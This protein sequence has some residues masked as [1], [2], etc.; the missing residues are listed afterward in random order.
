MDEA[1]FGLKVWHRRRWCPRGHR[2]PWQVEDRYEW[3]WLYAAVEPSTG[4]SFCLYMPHL[5]GDCFEVFVQKLRQAY[6]DDEIVLVLDGAGA[7]RK[8]DLAWPEGIEAMPLPAYS[9]E[10]N[11]AERWFEE[12]RARLAN[13]VFETTQAI[14]EAL[15]EALRPFW[16][17]PERLARLTGYGWW[18]ETISNIMPTS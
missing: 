5:N 4:E 3:L 12:L 8:K 17:A 1:R 6:P 9:P 16:E 10:L 11:P 13:R 2:P 15:T 14:E 18:I 7:H